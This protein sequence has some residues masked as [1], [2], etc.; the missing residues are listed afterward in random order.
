MVLESRCHGVRVA[1]PPVARADDGCPVNDAI[2][3]VRPTGG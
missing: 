2:T 1:C 3:Q